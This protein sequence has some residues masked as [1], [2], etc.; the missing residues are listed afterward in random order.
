[1][2]PQPREFQPSDIFLFES[3]GIDFVEA[4]FLHMSERILES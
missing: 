2:V 3:L 4:L 1:M